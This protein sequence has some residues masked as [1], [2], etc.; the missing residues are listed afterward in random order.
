MYIYIYIFVNA[1]HVFMLYLKHKQ[2]YFV[3]VFR[4]QMTLFCHCFHVCWSFWSACAPPTG[5]HHVAFQSSET[6][7]NMK[8]KNIDK[9]KRSCGLAAL[10]P[11]VLGMGMVFFLTPQKGKDIQ[12]PLIKQNI[13][14]YLFT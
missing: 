11:L 7:Q 10:V 4:T 6:H 8:I 3:T 12:Q 9:I 14:Y 13:L 1:L 5:V 2:L